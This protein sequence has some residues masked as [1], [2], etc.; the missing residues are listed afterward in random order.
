MISERIFFKSAFLSVLVFTYLSSN[1]QHLD[2]IPLSSFNLYADSVILSIWNIQTK[3]MSIPGDEPEEFSIQL[4]RK[5]LSG[6][7]GNSLIRQLKKQSS[8]DNTRALL[9]HYNLVFEFWLDGSEVTDVYV[10]TLTGNIDLVDTRS[11][12]AFENNC[13]PELSALI[14][15]FLRRYAVI[16]LLG[17]VG[18]DG[19]E[20]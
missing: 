14:L 4:D 18:T 6:T 1:A 13:S 8:F 2:S 7:D 16:D 11:E 20:F 10:S 15:E 19:L 17:D 12:S 5:R 9:Y 3:E